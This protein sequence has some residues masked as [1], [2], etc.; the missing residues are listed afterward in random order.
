MSQEFIQIGILFKQKFCILMSVNHR[1]L[2][3]VKDRFFNLEWIIFFLIQWN[4]SFMEIEHTC[5]YACVE[6]MLIF[7]NLIHLNLQ[8]FWCSVGK[9]FIELNV[10]VVFVVRICVCHEKSG[11]MFLQLFLGSTKFNAW[12]CD[13]KLLYVLSTSRFKT[14]WIF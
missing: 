5:F 10:S 6:I 11:T 2:I 13:V 8:F 14:L 1:G 9:F 7:E 12:E 4:I 3:Y